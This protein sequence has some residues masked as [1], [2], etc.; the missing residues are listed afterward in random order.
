MI[1][2][3]VKGRLGNQLFRYAAARRILHER[4]DKEKLLLGFKSFE[5]KA[6]EDGW[7]DWL[8]DF[9]V[10]NYEKTNQAVVPNMGN[11]LQY[12]SFYA[13]YL[14]KGVFK[15][16]HRK[17]TKDNSV[18]KLLNKTGLL[19][20]YK[21]NYFYNP[22]RIN[23]V[24]LDGWFENKEY[25]DSIKSIIQKEFTPKFEPIQHNME[26]YE[27]IANSNSVCISIRRGDYFSNPLTKSLHAVCREQ[28]FRKA[29]SVMKE[30]V[31]NPTFIFFSDDINWVKKNIKVDGCDCYY[32][33]G[34]DPVW[35]KLRLMYSCKH[36]II[37]NSSFSWWA[38]YLSRNENKIVISPNR[39]YNDGRTSDLLDESFIKIEP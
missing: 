31:V 28:Y 36:F 3:E 23:K 34:N 19:L 33:R 39:W 22:P 7:R 30:K 25:F 15:L 9:N 27:V 32:E 17:I 6:V 37:S 4:G 1:A 35:E 20:A 14:V 26:L 10:V 24:L 18:Y 12:L 29:M 21:N 38:Q 13:Q 5:G 2:L 16:I 8:E 11:L